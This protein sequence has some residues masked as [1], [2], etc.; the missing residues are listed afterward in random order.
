RKPIE[1]ESYREYYGVPEVFETLRTAINQ[2]DKERAQELVAQFIKK[3]WYDNHKEAGWYNSHKSKHNAYFG[4]WSFE[5]AAI[6]AIME[7]DDSNL[8]DCE[9]YPKDLVD[10]YQKHHPA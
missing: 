7:L 9:Y 2:T 4:Y 5:T 1:V 3:E 10:F 6:V 8:G